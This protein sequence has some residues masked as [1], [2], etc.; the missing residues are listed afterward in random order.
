MILLIRSGTDV[1]IFLCPYL[2]IS[3]DILVLHRSNGYDSKI[4][5]VDE[6]N[7]EIYRLKLFDWSFN[8]FK[9]ICWYINIFPREDTSNLYKF[10]ALP[11]HKEK[12]P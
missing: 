10:G 12:N 4:L 1:K 2:V 7:D 9:F 3:L 5:I 11:R 8:T 6:T